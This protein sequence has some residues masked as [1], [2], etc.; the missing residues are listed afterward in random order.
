[1]SENKFT[2]GEWEMLKFENESLTA[3]LR[4][5]KNLIDLLTE[6]PQL[7]S[8]APDLLEACEQLLSFAEYCDEDFR[9]STPSPDAEIL[10]RARKAIVKAK[11]EKS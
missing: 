2:K 4:A 9:N 6:N 7:I 11:G 1:M 8:A 5:A 3:N 10:E